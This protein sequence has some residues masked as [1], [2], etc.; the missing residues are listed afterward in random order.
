MTSIEK[1]IG[2]IKDVFDIVERHGSAEKLLFRGQDTDEQLL[3][4]F[5]RV[6][7]QYK[8]EDPLSFERELIDGFKKLSP[9]YLDRP[10]PQYEWD[11][12]ALARHYGLPTRLLDWTANAFI[13]LWFA[14]AYNNRKEDYKPVLWVLEARKKDIKSPLEGIEIEKLTRS[15]IFQPSHVNSRIA[16]QAGWLTIFRYDVKN[17]KFWPMDKNSNFRHN[18][19]KYKITTE[20]CDQ[21]KTDLVKMGMNRLYIFPELSSLSEVLMDEILK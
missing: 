16:A 18:L 10:I 20:A 9:L 11:W 2:S 14:V 12:L 7:Q 21:I 15:Y 19:T 5:A 17:Q 3:P 13:A 6:A 8:V 1:S 4:T